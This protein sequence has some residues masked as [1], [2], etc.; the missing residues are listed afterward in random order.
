MEQVK[1]IFQDRDNFAK[2]VGIE[3]LEVKQGYAKVKM[4]IEEQ[5]LNGVGTVHG[6]VIF[7][8]ADFALAAASNSH[9]RIAMGVNVNVTYLKAATAGTLFGEA[10]EVSLNHKLGHYLVN[11]SNE[12]RDLVAVFQGTVY[13][14]EEV[15]L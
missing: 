5:H 15:W 6:G 11:I 12:Q 13:R 7:T 8:M 4:A 3:L 1:Q 14:K 10:K 2:Y 9:G